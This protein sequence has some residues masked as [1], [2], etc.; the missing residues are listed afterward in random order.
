VFVLGPGTYQ[1]PKTKSVKPY[2]TGDKK[3]VSIRHKSPGESLLGVGLVSSLATSISACAIL[4]NQPLSSN[5]AY[6][7]QVLSR[8]MACSVPATYEGRIGGRSSGN[9]LRILPTLRTFTPA[10]EA[11]IL[12]VCTAKLGRVSN[13]PILLHESLKFYGQSLWELQRALWDPTQMHRDETFGACMAMIMYE[14]VE[15]PNSTMDAWSGHMRGCAKMFELKGPEYYGSEF[16][17]Q[18]FL[19]F[20]V[21]EVSPGQQSFRSV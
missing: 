19:S 1:G 12:A 4:K 20:R 15:C 17:H 14:V 7:Q 11:S 16:G 5:A 18:L 10:L 2:S 13:N 21:I 8:F 3:E 9:W 6:R